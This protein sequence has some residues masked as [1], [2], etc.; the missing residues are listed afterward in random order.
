MPSLDIVRAELSPRLNPRPVGLASRAIS[1]GTLLLLVGLIA[2]AFFRMDLGAWSIGIAYILYDTALL[3]FTATRV[4]NLRPDSL[5]APSGPRPSL[6]VIVAAYN[7]AE[8]LGATITALASQEDPPDLILLADDG[9]TDATAKRLRDQFGLEPP[10]E[11]GLSGPAPLLARLRWLRAPHGGKA[12]TLN[13]AIQQIDTDL[14]VTVDADT[15]LEPGAIRA[16]R[17]AFAAE[18]ELVAAT[19]VLQPI[20][21][22]SAQGRFFEWFQR[23]EYVRNFLSRH[24][25]MQPNALLLISGAFAAFRRSA[26]QE[27]GGFDPQTLV[28]DYE[29]IHRLH[30]FSRDRGLGWR[31][32]VIGGARARTDAPASLPAFLR[33]RRRWF[34]GFLQTH[35]WNRDMIAN[36]R[37]G[38]LGLAMLPVKSL[39]TM[40]PIFGILAFFILVWSIASGHFQIAL[41]IL[42]VMLAKVTLDLA[43]FVWSLGIYKRWT[44]TSEGLSLGPALV[45]VFIEPF[46]F[47]LMR[48]TGAILGWITFLTGRSDWGRPTRTALAADPHPL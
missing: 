38:A 7:E 10:R 25:W 1:V 23:Y 28:E 29:L 45:A 41:P 8:V 37:Y 48:H 46:T 43:F 34:G 19:G 33:Q 18:P 4:A 5:A 40:Q 11:S 36:R 39:D 17:S 32:R 24:A 22:P 21:G 31:I 16:M 35:Y 27:V 20:C 15:V 26:L 6:C 47:Q 13:L 42:A 3:G 44:E 2:P 9:S 14:I 30:R 12:R